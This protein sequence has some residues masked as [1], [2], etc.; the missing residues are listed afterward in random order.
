MVLI[1]GCS[2]G[3]GKMGEAGV[4]GGV[5]GGSGYAE[6]DQYGNLVAVDPA[7]ARGEVMAVS[8]TAPGN[9]PGQTGLE[10]STLP[11]DIFGTESISPPGGA[12][13]EPGKRQGPTL[14][15]EKDQTR[16]QIKQ[17]RKRRRSLISEEE[18][19]EL[20]AGPVYRRSILG[21]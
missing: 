2:N 7:F 1:L 11:G 5:D 21:G 6:T 13:A 20:G 14:Q 9:V 17:K 16:E 8:P 15:K 10:G 3:G 12:G 18:E 19:G 4:N